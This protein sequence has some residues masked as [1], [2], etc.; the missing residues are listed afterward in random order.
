MKL[1]LD[2][3]KGNDELVALLEQPSGI[4]DGGNIIMSAWEA[5]TWYGDGETVI[6]T[7]PDVLVTISI[8]T[9]SSIRDTMIEEKSFTVD[10][11]IEFR[12]RVGRQV[13]A[14]WAQ[15]VLDE[16]DGVMTAQPPGKWRA[17]GKSGG[18]NNVGWDSELKRYIIGGR[19]DITRRD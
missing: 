16:I 4:D 2:R 8:I 15:R 19:Y 10:V 13:P 17:E 18:L 5:K 11:A 12:R 3:L 14:S 6:Q 7:A 1:V 9:G